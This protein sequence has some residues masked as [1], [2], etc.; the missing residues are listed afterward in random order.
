MKKYFEQPA[1][2]VVRVNKYDI[3]TASKFNIYDNQSIGTPGAVL[4]PGQRG[5]DDWDA[6][7]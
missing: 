4:A 2:E 7:Y 6:G 3:V 1:L 5:F